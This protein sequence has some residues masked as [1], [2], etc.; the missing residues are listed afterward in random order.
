M[1]I[2]GFMVTLLPIIVSPGASFAIALNSTLTQGMKGLLIPII[3][4]GLGIMTH[5]LLVGIGLTK[6]LASY[7]WVMRSIGIL[8]TLYL[9]YLSISLINTGIKA[10]KSTAN[11]T[12]RT[13]TV[14]DAYLAN[15]LNPKAIVLY[16]VVV[17]NFV[18]NDPSLMSFLILSSIH[19]LMMAAWLVLS[20]GS[21]IFFSS[22]IQ[23]NTLRK[24]IN[25]GGGVLLLIII[26]VPYLF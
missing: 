17:S 21:L 24:Y 15:L 1:D 6:I 5:G 10:G 13:V 4:T 3:G 19:V 23:V 2:L 8:G 26:L 18:G 16:L 22:S 11:N 14:R 7:P 20:C 9:V 12:M 25:I